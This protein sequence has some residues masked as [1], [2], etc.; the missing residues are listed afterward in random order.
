MDFFAR[1]DRARRNTQLLVAYFALAVVLIVVAL[2][3]VAAAVVRG[4][5]AY[6]QVSTIQYDRYGQPI[7]QPAPPSLF[8]PQIVAYVTLGTLIVIVGGSIYKI[9]QL[10]GGGRAVAEMMGAVP[11]PPDT[12]DSQ[13]RTLRN[14]IEEMSIASGVP[15]PGVWL[16]A[17][18]KGINAFAAGHSSRDAVICV[19]QGCLDRLSRDELQGVVA[20]EFSHILND[21][22]RLDLRLV[23]ILYGILL[24]GL[25]GY[26]ILRS[27]GSTRSSNDK[28]AGGQIALLVIG[29]VVAAIGFIGLFFGRLI[30]A[31]VCRQREF[32]A[33]AAAVQFTRNPGGLAGALKKL[34]AMGSG[35]RIS[36]PDAE[37]I[38]HMFF[39]SSMGIE[40]G[41]FATH[42]PIAQRIRAIDPSWDGKFP[43]HQVSPAMQQYLEGRPERAG[44]AMGAAVT[45]AGIVGAVGAPMPRHIA[46]ASDFLGSI[47]PEVNAAA[48]QPFGARALVFAL[49]LSEQPD[50]RQKQLDLLGRQTDSAT[51]NAV[52]QLSG[53]VTAYG[54][55][56]RR[57][58]L[59]LALPALRQLS[60]PQCLQF[61][62]IVRGM[63]E[64]DGQVS[65][66]EYMLHRILDK[67]LPAGPVA[68]PLP[69]GIYAVKPLLPAIQVVLSALATADQ[70]DTASAQVAF[71]CG[72]DQ[73]DAGEPLALQQ[74]VNL[75]QMD[76]A[77]AQLAQAAPG[78]KRRIVNACAYCVSADG[79][80]Q[81]E[82]GELLR[83]ITTAL[84]CPLPPLLTEHAA[85]PQPA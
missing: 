56:G 63:I 52:S 21:D 67:Y 17:N 38:A 20:H 53:S 35:S 15:A 80:V 19:T 1:Q 9:G 54:P 31:A 64:A 61:H 24:I 58:L 18:E 57:V 60:G 30:Q 68:P 10:A 40:W 74:S 73:L 28:N 23:G 26:G 7:P 34:G 82:E 3:L 6:R 45:A 50:V 81:T 84:D 65:L 12:T 62:Q 59:D 14:V 66:F 72:A 44:L 32:L 22:V 41:A 48:R 8:Q 29:A 25:I 70:K 69:G 16:L 55:R 27:A 79:M 85:T 43:P 77:L 76:D 33:D 2:N 11:V 83:A 42:P 5:F 51:L 46:W 36:D 13:Q 75:K 78:V 4:N 49:L 47:P 37:Q 71:T 39:G